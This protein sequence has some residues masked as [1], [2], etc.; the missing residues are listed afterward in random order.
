MQTATGLELSDCTHSASAVTLATI[1]VEGKPH[2][3]KCYAPWQSGRQTVEA[4]VSASFADRHGAQVKQFLPLLVSLEDTAGAIR[5]VA[6]VRCAA[7]GPLFL[8]QYLQQPI[9]SV[10]SQQ[11]GVAVCREDVVEV[12]NLA[13]EGGY[14]R[15]LFV[16]LSDVLRSWNLQWLVFTGTR[17]VRNTFK[18][19]GLLPWDLGA[20][21][22]ECLQGDATEWG[23]Y[24]AEDPHVMAG[25]IKAGVDAL[26]E[27]QVYAALGYCRKV[28]ELQMV[29]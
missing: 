24:Y 29:V 16:A 7:F 17:L 2:R 25:P 20:A 19:I 15:F 28:D 23:R 26:R 6:G 10:L 5:S 4:F 1:F 13:G 9:E 14:S 21:R 8:E 11:A 18:R 12:G 27:K 22:A 3:I